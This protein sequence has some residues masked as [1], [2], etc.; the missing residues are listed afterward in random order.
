MPNHFHLVL[1]TPQANLVAGM[2]WFL[3]TYTARFNRR[4]KLFGHLFSG[5]Y[6]S[7]I[8]DGSGDGYLRTVCDYVHLNPVRAKLLTADRPLSDYAWS[9][10][11]EYLKPPGKRAPWLRVDRLFGEMG[12][13]QDSVVGRRQFGSAMEQR[14][15]QETGSAWKGVERGWCLGDETFRQE[16]LAQA[17]G[18]FGANHY[19]GQQQEST[20]EKARRILA[21]ELRSLGWR[22]GEL[23]RRLKADPDKVRIARRLRG[24]TTVTLKWIAGE[25]SMGNWTYLSN[26]L[27]KPTRSSPAR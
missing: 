25:L 13:A 7:L 9:S 5:R 24:E 20:E 4:H 8:V 22:H 21:E 19:A 26:N 27:S 14:R 6:K 11:G 16:L 10:H 17:E 12:I 15:S 18:K 3:G 1:E 23:E 2:K